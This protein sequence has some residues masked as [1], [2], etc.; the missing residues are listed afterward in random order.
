MW[1]EIVQPSTSPTPHAVPAVP[2][3]AWRRVHALNCLRAAFQDADLAIDMSAHLAAGLQV[4]ILGMA[5][6]EWQVGAV[7][8]ADAL[9]FHVLCCDVVHCDALCSDMRRRARLTRKH[10]RRWIQASCGAW[11]LLCTGAA[12]LSLCCRLPAAPS[13]PMHPKQVRNAASLCY[14]A[15]LIR[16]LGFRN[17]GTKVRRG[18]GKICCA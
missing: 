11:P 1:S 9:Y 15:L 6:A 13:P 18:R 17:R 10:K 2:A 3:V 7:L 12:E 14:T 8:C 5:A 16:V 4:A